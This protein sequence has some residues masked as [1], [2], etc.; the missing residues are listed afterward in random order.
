MSYLSLLTGSSDASR[1][2]KEVHVSAGK[3]GIRFSNDPCNFLHHAEKKLNSLQDSRTNCYI[4]LINEQDSHHGRE[5]GGADSRHLLRQNHSE[6]EKRRRDK[7]NT[8]ISEL[9]SMIPT[10]KV[11]PYHHIRSN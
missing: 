6:I 10:C 3:L 4:I 8:Y 2:P 7:M 11:R 9:S 5:E 1:R